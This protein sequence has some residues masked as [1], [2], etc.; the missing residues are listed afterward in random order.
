MNDTEFW[1]AFEEKYEKFLSKRRDA[2]FFASMKYLRMVEK[3]TGGELK[4]FSIVDGD[5]EIEG[6]LP[7]IIKDTE[8]GKIMNTLPFYGSNPGMIS[9]VFRKKELLNA[10]YREAQSCFSA[11][12]IQGI[13]ESEDIYRQKEWTFIDQSRMCLT[14]YLHPAAK[15]GE[16]LIDT[17][18]QKTRNQIRKGQKEGLQIKRFYNPIAVRVIEKMHNLACEEKG[19]PAKPK[20]F[21][22]WLRSP[23]I[24]TDRRVFIYLAFVNTLPVAGLVCFLQNQ[25]MEYYLPVFDKRYSK[26]APLNSIIYQAMLDEK[27]EGATWFNWGGTNKETMPGVYHFKKRFN[28]IG[29]QYGY[30]TLLSDDAIKNGIP[31]KLFIENP[32]FFIAPFSELQEVDNAYIYKIREE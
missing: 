27:K 19:F 23:E 32:Y 16:N 1:L 12:I 22:E 2:S 17:F 25:T 24:L 7:V 28:A 15:D 13:Y 11:T 31:R 8:C 14:T 10:F 30:Y 9:P 29:S 4:F 20:Q 6:V 3:I 5:M 26:I 21:F 18:H